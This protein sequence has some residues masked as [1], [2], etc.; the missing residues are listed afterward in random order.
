MADDEDANLYH[1][2]DSDESG[3][4]TSGRKSHQSITW[5]ASEFIEHQRGA[6]WYALLFLI[7]AVLAAAIYFLIHDYFATAIIIILGILVGLSAGHKPGQT[8]YELSSSELKVGTRPYPYSQFKSFAIIHEGP[9]STITFYPLK[10]LALPI[11]I[12]FEA[13]DESRIV[14]LIGDHLPLEARG[15]DR[16]DNLTRRLKI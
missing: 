16:F 7:T 3:P 12:F 15:P 5:T 10:R 6:S 8:T 11:S 2:E 14:K 13:K 9:L 4:N 1:P